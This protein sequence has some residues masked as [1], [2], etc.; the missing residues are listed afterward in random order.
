MQIV[1]MSKRF[2]AITE[3]KTMGQATGDHW[4]DVMHTLTYPE[5][6][7]LRSRWEA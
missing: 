5:E 3:Q 6:E 7:M 4:S 2:K 1:S